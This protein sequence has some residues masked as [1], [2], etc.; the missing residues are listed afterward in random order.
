MDWHSCI[1]A[2]DIAGLLS[3]GHLKE[4]VYRDRVSSM[5]DWVAKLHAALVTIDAGILRQVQASIPQCV[6][7]F[8]SDC[9]V[10]TLNTWWC[11]YFPQNMYHA[12]HSLSAYD[13]H[14]VSVV[15]N[16]VYCKMD[17]VTAFELI[18]FV[19]T[20]VPPVSLLLFNHVLSA[21]DVPVHQWHHKLPCYCHQL[22]CC[23][24]WWYFLGLYPGDDI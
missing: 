20:W 12:V 5:E 3:L 17:S 19:N 7:S 6:W 16:H 8:V 13:T 21:C 4:L 1:L 24:I 2:C 15:S 9:R 22:D 18:T 11:N 10:D 23:S 14:C